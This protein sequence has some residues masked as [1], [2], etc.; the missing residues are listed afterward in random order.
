M[1]IDWQ[2][3]FA[4]RTKNI[5]GSQI[6]QFF[7]LTERPEI[8]SFAGGFPDNDF[9][10]RDDIAAT[11]AQMVKEEGQ[12]ALQYGPTEGSYELR[13]LLA[14]K[15]SLN[16]A[17]CEI[18]NLIITNGSQQGLDLL[19][20]TLVN[21]GDAVLVEE[22]AYIGGVGAIKSYGGNPVGITID[23][24]GPIP[25]IMEE[26]IKKL[27]KL[28]KKPRMFYTVPNFQNPTGVTTSLARRLDILAIADHYNLVIIEDDP[29]SELC[30]EGEVPPSYKSLDQCDRVIYLGSYSKVI[31]PG[32]RIGWIAGSEPLMEKVTLAKQTTDL[33]SSSLG[34]LLSY[35]LSQDGY[36][37]RHI[38]RLNDHYRQKKNTM[39]DSMQQSFPADVTFSRPRGGFFI[40]VSF[41]SHF[42]TSKELL[43]M[44]LKRQV[45]FVHGEGFFSNGG[46]SHTARFS[47]SQPKIEDIH[48]GIKI[49]GDILLEIH[50]HSQTKAAII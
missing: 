33:C 21:S 26:T 18:N 25:E 50:V 30:Y 9:F 16:G 39:L 49:F 8:I 40:W 1:T 2:N 23:Q 7:A 48:A 27:I 38:A 10:P 14:G 45:A 20:R 3:F 6:R 37:D 46:G 4:H 5:T 31:I 15:M 43:T 34:Q 44:A 28:G 32:I 36:L 19:C 17:P 47:F 22:P 12:L 11:L 24:D 41:P 29:Y 42:P 13:V 35:R